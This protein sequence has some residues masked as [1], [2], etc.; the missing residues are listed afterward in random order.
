MRKIFWIVL[1]ALL[2]PCISYAQFYTGS[3]M[4]FGKNRVQH[5]EFNWTFY[6][7]DKYQIYF[8]EGGMEIAKY[9][10]KSAKK[11]ITEIE[12]LF[13]HTLETKLQFIVYNKQSEFMTSNL[14]LSTQEQYNTGGVTRIVGSKV[15]IYF[16]GD[17]Q[18]LEQVIRAGIAEVILNQMMY[19]GDVKDMLK[20]STLLTLPDWYTQGL[21]S[22]VSQGWNTTLDNR[23]RD[24]ITNGTFEKFNRL[25]GADAVAAGHSIWQYVADT[26]GENVISNILYMTK[27][28]RNIESA[29]LFVLGVSVKNLSYEWLESYNKRYNDLDKTRTLPSQDAVIKKPKASRIYNQAKLSPD[30]K[31]LVYVTNEAGQYKVWLYDIETQK[32]KRL[33]KVGHKIERINDLSYPLIAWHPSGKHFSLIREHETKVMLG[34]YILETG[35]YDE[36]P[37]INFE[38]VTDFSYADD[39]K[40]FVMSAVQNGQSDIYVFTAASNAFEQITKDLYDDIEPRFVHNS[41]EIIFVSNRTDDT[42]RFT[43]KNEVKVLPQ[44]GDIFVYNY[45]AKSKVLRRL[46]NTP[47]ILESDPAAYDSA[48]YSFISDKNGIRNRF[49]AVFDSVIAY[50]DTAEHYRYVVNSFPVTNYER[51][52][53]EHDVNLK[54][55]K[56]TEVIYLDGKYRIYISSLPKVAGAT[57]IKLKNTYYR[58]AQVR[59]REMKQLEEEL[60]RQ[61]KEKERK[62]KEDEYKRRQEAAAKDTTGRKLQVI[63][64][65]KEDTKA[66]SDTSGKTIDINNYTFNNEKGTK[67]KQ[68]AAPAPKDTVIAQAP[69]P[70]VSPLAADSIAKKKQQDDED[71]FVFSKQRNY[72][73]NYFTDYVVTQL[74]NSFLNTTYQ[75]FTGGGSPIYLNPGFTLFSKVGMSDLFEDYRIVGGMRLSGNLNSNEY[76]LSFENRIGRVDKQLVLHRQALQNVSGNFSLVKVHTHDVQYIVKYPFSE[77]ASVRGTIAARNDRTVYLATDLN[78]LGRKHKYDNW[79]NLKAEYIFDN[80]I[81]R[82]LNLYNGWRAKAFVEYFRQVDLDSLEFNL[83][84]ENANM[85]V[86]GFDVRHYQKIH[87]DFIWANRIAASTSFGGQ[88]LIYYMGGVDNWLFPKFD[89]SI[90]VATDQN[91]A[92]QTLATPMRGFYQNIRNGNSF[93]VINSELRMPL[94]RYLLNRPIRSDFVNNFQVIG[95]GDIGTAWTGKSPYSEENSLNKTVLGSPGNPITVILNSQ[96]EPIIGGYGFGFRS[97]IWGYFVRVDWAWGIEDGVKLPKQSYL[98]FS[99]DF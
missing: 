99:L 22:Y 71:E 85:V 69:A 84:N 7:Y 14:G 65:P 28:S 2:F 48:H 29:F 24:G 40:K 3:Q 37:M 61:Q 33:M 64:V 78:N 75:K 54:A 50:V 57:P 23:V 46:T 17:H 42:I 82:G 1:L 66:K 52:I 26:Y 98:S 72:T 41:R 16:D 56:I 47:G 53:V 73:V 20:N 95:F 58:D 83:E 67:E 36:R 32:H 8:Y 88:K 86:A 90:N 59:A 49:A 44:A 12:R 93:A 6:N 43:S 81:K 21:I 63:S 91:Y 62:K 97:R 94:F 51:N 96:K 18:K 31:D 87:R 13:D 77:V 4:E 34:Q 79:A 45:A 68:A 5:K 25:T 27:V 60:A 74:D 39:G 30:G 80:S 55:G 19:G 15:S 35:E 11:N 76:F 89:R 38:K 9:V 70:K 10:S 92:Y